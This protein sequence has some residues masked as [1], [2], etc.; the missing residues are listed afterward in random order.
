MTMTSLK[1]ERKNS[2]DPWCILNYLYEPETQVFCFYKIFSVFFV[3]AFWFFSFF[4]YYLNFCY[5]HF[6]WFN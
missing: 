2:I 6:I 4:I 5:S 1:K 3:Q